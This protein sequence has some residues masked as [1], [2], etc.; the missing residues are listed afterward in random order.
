MPA[1]VIAWLLLLVVVVLQ[2]ILLLRARGG[3]N[4]EQ[5]LRAE[6]A[7]NRGEL[8]DNLLR[9]QKAIGEQITNIAKLQNDQ[10]T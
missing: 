1:D 10:L 3:G 9:L 2:V 7:T 8:A 6:S 4:L 5:A